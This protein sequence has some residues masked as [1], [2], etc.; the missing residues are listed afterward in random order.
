MLN[1]FGSVSRPAGYVLYEPRSI[2]YR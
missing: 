1:K 2:H